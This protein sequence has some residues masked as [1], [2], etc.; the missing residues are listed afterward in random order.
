MALASMYQRFVAPSL[1]LFQ[2]PA[3]KAALDSRMYQLISGVD[4][5]EL[6]HP[7]D[8]R[9]FVG[10]AILQQSVRLANSQR[11][12]THM[13]P[14][15]TP[16]FLGSENEKAKFQ[17]SSK[18]IDEP[19]EVSAELQK[20]LLDMNGF[21]VHRRKSTVENAG[22]GLFMEGSVP[23]GTVIAFV[24]GTVYAIDQ[25]QSIPGYPNLLRPKLTMSVGLDGT[26]IDSDDELGMEMYTDLEWH[27]KDKPNPY[28]ILQNSYASGHFANHPPKNG[29]HNCCS[30]SVRF[31]L[32]ERNF[33]KNLLPY[34]Q[35]R[36]TRNFNY[37]RKYFL[38]IDANVIPGIVLV[39]TTDI[40]DGDEIFRNYQFNPKIPKEKVPDWYW[41][42]DPELTALRWEST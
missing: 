22:W 23:P 36:K 20:R 37:I 8:V 25:I 39:S 24:P 18:V 33:L 10:D 30:F 1:D 40:N 2:R 16:F 15:L 31:G 9:D 41:D 29:I 32:E 13:P 42:P 26:L 34:V 38:K 17:R 4:P 12:A 28:W 27:K 7:D 6:V 35:C 11:D 21:L 19:M 5:K 14:P 3:F